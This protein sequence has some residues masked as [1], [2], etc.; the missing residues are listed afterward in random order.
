MKSPLWREPGDPALYTTSLAIDD[1][2]AVRA[3]LGY[4]EINLYGGS[5]GTRVALSYLKYHEATTRAVIVD[6][7]VPQDLALGPGIAVES[8]RALDQMFARCA[9]DAACS[10][11][12]PTL[13][14]DFAAVKARLQK[15][16]V[17]H[18][19]PNLGSVTHGNA[20]SHYFRDPAGNRIEI[21]F[22]TEWY[23]HQPM[24]LAIDLTLPDGELWKIIEAHARSQPG[25][26][27]RAAWQADLKQKI[28]QAAAAMVA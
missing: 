21:F 5:Y 7:V 8:Q 4:A 25:F 3:A 11:A 9:E 14:Q 18:E 16:P 23:V 26:T 13:G 22:D 24:R 1:L 20:V 15:A 6:A 28:A 17:I 27:T 12:F 19:G 10:K 2:D